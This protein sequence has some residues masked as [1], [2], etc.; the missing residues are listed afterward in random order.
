MIKL[1]QEFA[2]PV[3][4][5][6]NQEKMSNQLSLRQSSPWLV[7]GCITLLRAMSGTRFQYCHYSLVQLNNLM[8]ALETGKLF[9]LLPGAAADHLPPSISLVIGLILGLVGYGMGSIFSLHTKS[10]ICLIGKCYY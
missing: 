3:N 9:G 10:P 2:Y 4:I 1:N 8:V 7:L 6:N 5:Q